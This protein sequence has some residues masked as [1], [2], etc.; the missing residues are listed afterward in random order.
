[1]LWEE[2]ARIGHTSGLFHLNQERTM[3]TNPQQQRNNSNGTLYMS[4]EL[5]AE[6]WKLGFADCL[7]RNARVRTIAAGDFDRLKEEVAI[8]KERFELDVDASVICCY[9]AGRDGFWVHRCLVLLGFESHIVDPASIQVSRKKRRAKTDRIDAQQIVKA[10]IRFKAGDDLACRM[11]RIPDVD[12]EDARRINREMRTLKTERTAHNNRIKSLLNLQGIRQVIIDGSFPRR[13]TRMKTAEGK[14]LCENLQEEIDREFDR[15]ALVASQ[16]RMLQ[17]KQMK[18]IR[19]VAKEIKQAKSQDALLELDTSNCAV[20]AEFLTRLGG[21]GP[22]TAWTLSSEVFSWR[23]H[24]NRRQL[25]SL[26]GLTPTPH[27]SGGAEKEQGI[28]KSGRGELRI[29]MIEIAW[30]WLRHQPESELTKWYQRRFNDGTKR[31]RKIGIVAL[32]RKLL[33]AIS[34]FIRFGE[35]PAGATLKS[36]LKTGYQVLLKIPGT[37]LACLTS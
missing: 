2:R 23:D 31:N 32:A 14:P 22:V 36:E 11:I 15:M 4:L 8:A 20:T 10:L 6:N 35:V 37:E 5:A 34:K 18:L 16:L 26:V 24:L 29:L 13:L 30:G 27:D 9:E 12:A 7:G 25:A 1:M 19:Q 3:N 21:I 17:M 33:V 28:S